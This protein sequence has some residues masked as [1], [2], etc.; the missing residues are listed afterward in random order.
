MKNSWWWAKLWWK[1][2]ID[3]SV[4]KVAV[5]QKLKFCH[6][7]TQRDEKSGFLE[8]HTDSILLE[9][10]K[11]METFY[12]RGKKNMN[13][14]VTA[15]SVLFNWSS[16][17]QH[18]N[19]NLFQKTFFTPFFGFYTK[20]FAVAADLKGE[21]TPVQKKTHGLESRVW[22]TRASRWDVWGHFMFCQF[23]LI[24]NLLHLHLPTKRPLT[25]LLHGAE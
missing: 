9:Q 3:R 13:I 21:Q 16:E 17:I 4:F 7:C 20:I 10:P 15:P 18:S 25:F 11:K 22:T 1:K 19:F 2:R 24:R 6:S 23:V 5:H 12:N 8:R 14:L